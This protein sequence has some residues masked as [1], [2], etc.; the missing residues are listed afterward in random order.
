MED[1]TV[2]CF[3]L[4]FTQQYWLIQ[5]AIAEVSH[6]LHCNKQ[7]LPRYL[8]IISRKSIFSDHN[9]FADEGNL[10]IG[11][12]AT[13]ARASRTVLKYHKHMPLGSGDHDRNKTIIILPHFMS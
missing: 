13:H 4:N 7:K 11:T 2:K 12:T 5:L 8:A 3:K 10:N 9:I 6:V 1:L